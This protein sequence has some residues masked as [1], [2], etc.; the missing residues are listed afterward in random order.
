MNKL[1]IATLLLTSSYSLAQMSKV[2]S[3]DPIIDTIKKIRSVKTNDSDIIRL[4]KKHNQSHKNNFLF[5][6]NEEGTILTH[7]LT[8]T[9]KHQLK[10]IDK[11]QSKMI[12]Q[13]IRYAQTK[14]NG[15]Y[16][17]KVQRAGHKNVFKQRTYIEKLG[18]IIVASS[19][20]IN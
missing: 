7:P 9:E 18:K 14:G 11:T 6:V 8:S 10:T 13:I 4:I 3:D 20:N 17:L 19:I 16:Q 12:K 1:I 15:W 5:A 2:V